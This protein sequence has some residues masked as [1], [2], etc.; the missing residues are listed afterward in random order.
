MTTILS[1]AGICLATYLAFHVAALLRAATSRENAQA[2]Y[3]KTAES[4]RVK[5]A[6]SYI[7]RQKMASGYDRRRTEIL[8]FYVTEKI[9]KLPE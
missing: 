4:Q 1:L 8:E 6:D 7:S 2:S 3:F 5:E 9:D